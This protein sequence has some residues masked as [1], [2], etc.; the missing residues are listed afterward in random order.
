VIASFRAA[1]GI[2]EVP[3][4]ADKCIKYFAFHISPSDLAT[5]GIWLATSNS[6]HRPSTTH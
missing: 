4:A 3:S 5:G 1:V 2:K 6:T